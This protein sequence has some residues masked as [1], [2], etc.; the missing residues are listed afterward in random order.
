MKTEIKRILSDSSL[1]TE[2]KL[3]EIAAIVNNDSYTYEIPG[4]GMVT[5]KGNSV[6]IDGSKSST[7]IWTD[8]P[9]GVLDDKLYYKGGCTWGTDAEGKRY[10][11]LYDKFKDNREGFR[12]EIFNDDDVY[13]FDEW[14]R[15]KL[16]SL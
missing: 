3:I 11:K 16:K 4:L 14:L 15:R 5:K 13:D 2:D 6:V 9:V 1:S 12:Y 10:W 8:N 7:A